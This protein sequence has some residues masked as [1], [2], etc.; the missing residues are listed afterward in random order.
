MTRKKKQAPRPTKTHINHLPFLLLLQLF[1]FN[2]LNEILEASDEGAEEMSK[3][4]ST[5]KN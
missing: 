2:C 3:A 4:H 1:P 5:S